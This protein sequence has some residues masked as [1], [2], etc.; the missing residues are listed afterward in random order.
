[1]ADFKTLDISDF[2]A[3]QKLNT[4]GIEAIINAAAYTKVDEAE[5][6]ENLSLAWSVNSQGPA[7]P[8]S[9]AVKLNVPLVHI[10]TDY[11]FDGQKDG[12]YLEDDLFNPSAFTE[13][14]KLLEI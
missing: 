14:A 11:V 13:P 7:N 12:A 10:S 1:M 3:V 6:P 8:A 9:L 2:S 5:K 4:D